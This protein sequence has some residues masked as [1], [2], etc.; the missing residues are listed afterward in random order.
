MNEPAQFDE[1]WQRARQ[2]FESLQSDP[3]GWLALLASAALVLAII[4]LLAAA[5][6]TLLRRQPIHLL[7]PPYWRWPDAVFVLLSCFTLEALTSMLLSQLELGAASAAVAALEQPPALARWLIDEL[8]PLLFSARIVVHVLLRVGCVVAIFAAL[9]LRNSATSVLGL[10]RRLF[11]AGLRVGALTYVCIVLPGWLVVSSSWTLVLELMGLR[12]EPQALAGIFIAAAA[13][14]DHF[15]LVS[16]FCA[17]AVV[18]PVF[19]EVVFRGLLFRSLTTAVGARPA[20]LISSLVFT[21]VHVNLQA[22][23]PI[24]AIGCVLASLY[25]RTGNLWAC[26]TLHSIFNGVQ[27]LL[28]WAL[29]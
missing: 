24:F 23:L 12:P 5:F 18:A 28:M 4:A 25:H 2:F 1:V 29:V 15:L 6:A 10:D 21:V 7:A 8:R 19:E 27:F 20:V 13:G 16:L 17:G 3:L 11:G 26:I 22:S 9:S 14:D